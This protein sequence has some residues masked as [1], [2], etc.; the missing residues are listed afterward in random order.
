MKKSKNNWP[1]LPTDEAAQD[2]VATADLSEFDWSAAE[3]QQNLRHQAHFKT[4][5]LP[6]QEP[7]DIKF[8]IES[9]LNDYPHLIRAKGFIRNLEGDLKTLQIVGKRAEVSAAPAGVVE[10]LVVIQQQG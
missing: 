8:F 9:L 2:F 6:M 4:C 10:G 5:S 1:S 7:V 3:E